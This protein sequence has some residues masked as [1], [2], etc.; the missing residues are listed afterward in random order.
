MVPE[1]KEGKMVA[2]LAFRHKPPP[3]TILFFK[4]RGVEV[5]LRTP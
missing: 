2:R 3:S 5:V 4:E 1:L